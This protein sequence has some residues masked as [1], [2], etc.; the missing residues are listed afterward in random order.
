MKLGRW[1]F[2]TS[3]NGGKES[4]VIPIAPQFCLL[5]S[6]GDRAA[7]G[8]ERSWAFA[9]PA[10]S[11]HA[12]LSSVSPFGRKLLLSRVL[13]VLG[14]QAQEGWPGPMTFRAWS[15]VLVFIQPGLPVWDQKKG[16]GRTGPGNGLYG[17]S[18][19]RNES[20]P[21]LGTPNHSVC[22]F[23]RGGSPWDQH[24]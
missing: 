9:Q 16:D 4:T 1:L 24:P 13:M 12:L 21:C 22:A 8:N 18:W 7:P 10:S 11:S 23:S 20:M 3:K 5:D 15:G 2:L 17:P 6:H 19:S 14:L